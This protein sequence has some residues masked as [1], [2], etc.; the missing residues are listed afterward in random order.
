M[1]DYSLDY[2]FIEERCLFS[3][4]VDFLIVEDPYSLVFFYIFSSFDYF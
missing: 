4:I 2:F 1:T 3:T